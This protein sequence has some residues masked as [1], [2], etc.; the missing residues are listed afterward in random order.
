MKLH[1]VCFFLPSAH[2]DGAE[3]SALEC[4][5]ALASLGIQCRVVIP[6]KGPLITELKSRQLQYKLIPYR[7]WIEPPVP[8]WKRLLVTFWNLI[9]AYWA[10]L[11]LARWKCDLIITNT[12]NICVGALV[13]KILGLPHLWYLREFGYE[14]HGWQYH[15]G[16]KPSLWLMDRLSVVCAAVSR[17][18]AEKYQAGMTPS[19][20]QYLYQPINV[21]LTTQADVVIDTSPFQFTCIMVGRLQQGKRQEDAIRAV[22][23]LRDRG[24]QVQ[25]WL[26]GGGD[27]DY[28]IFLEELVREKNLP[29]QVR[30]WGQVENALPYIQQADVLLLCSRCEAFAR[31]VV[32]AM[33][34]GKPVIGTRSG[35]TVEQ[36]KDGFNGFLYE[37]RDHKSLAEKIKYLYEHPEK[38]HEM[39]RN[40][41][42]YAMNTFT[43]E[44]YR[45]E[46][47]RI[48]SSPGMKSSL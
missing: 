19:K 4:L 34:A 25:L 10:T 42:Q 27:K 36:I 5:D 21:D 13:A 45:G 16:K 2:R 18:V 39:G 20:V 38:A 1:Q 8:I 30:F 47:I 40:G 32:E 43:K 3:L 17:A 26:V 44:R 12:I 46:I 28:R 6:Q 14:D 48:F 37:P 15:L 31:V 11:V 24:L 9:M 33:K 35:G 7:V 23:E 41:R 29:G 22:G